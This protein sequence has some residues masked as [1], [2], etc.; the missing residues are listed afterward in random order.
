MDIVY[1]GRELKLL[2]AFVLRQKKWIFIEEN[3]MYF[4]TIG[5][6]CNIEDSLKLESKIAS[7]FRGPNLKTEYLAYITEMHSIVIMIQN[8]GKWAVRHKFKIPNLNI[9]KLCF[10]FPSINTS[11]TNAFK[12]KLFLLVHG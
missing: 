11:T 4:A 3:R 8:H 1:E 6:K 5:D 7:I 2:N 9:R 10:Y 12:D